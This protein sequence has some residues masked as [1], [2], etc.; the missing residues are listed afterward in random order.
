MVF[1]AGGYVTVRPC[2]H[3][4]LWGVLLPVACQKI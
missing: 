1:G 2:R 3:E 4:E